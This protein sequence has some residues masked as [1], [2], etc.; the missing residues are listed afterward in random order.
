MFEDAI[1]IIEGKEALAGD[2]I[3][4]VHKEGWHKG[5]LGIAA[6]K[7]VEKYGRPAIV[8][9]VED[10]I[11][12]GSARSVEG[13][14]LNEAFAHCARL[15][16]GYGGHKRAAGLKVK[17]HM[18]AELRQRLN[19]YAVDI[20]ADGVPDLVLDVDAELPLG[21]GSGWDDRGS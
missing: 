16:E 9:S 3:L 19:A 20:F 17:D 1:D 8:I 6:S 5:V 11:G 15:L 14:A 18:I 13:F 12:V 10:G 2:R 7:I 21:D 4:L